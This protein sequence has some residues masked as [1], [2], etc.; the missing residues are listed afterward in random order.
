MGEEVGKVNEE[1]WVTLATN[2]TYAIGALV[3]AHSLK[4]VGTQRKL[5]ILVTKSLES[6]TMR[7]ALEETFDVVQDVEEMDSF[8]A[9]NLKLLQ[10]PELGIT[11]TKLHCWCLTQ[12]SKCVF[13]DADT[14]VMKF[15]DELFDRKE[16]SAAPD[17]GWP[18]CFNSGVFVF[19]PSVETFES[20][21]AFA[22]KEG[23]FDGGDQGLLNSY[24]DTW[25]T[26]DIETHLPFVYNMC[27]T[28]TYTYLPAYKKFGES[29]KIV[30]FI[31]MSK[32]WDAQRD[33]QSGRPISRAQD[34]HAG[35]HLEKW[36]SIYEA[37][38]K[39]ILQHDVSLIGSFSSQHP[40]LVH[41][42]NP[43]AISASQNARLV[44]PPKD[45][46]LSWEKGCPDYMGTASFDKILERIN[47]TLLEEEPESKK[48]EEPESK[49]E[50]E[51]REDES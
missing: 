30:H 11:F 35:D 39:P 10:R 20:L 40:S 21:V 2:E 22:Q 15:C 3:L 1:A 7:K 13:L 33:S 42:N 51:Q 50:E 4:K 9:V 28:A 34:S 5:A 12:F 6:K 17:A 16:L 27:A 49:K 32:P 46:R 19:K 18:D 44:C 29:V 47:T 25:A 14:F 23:S 48:E 37:H 24:F 26:Q 8:D 45:N 36:W 43:S 41:E 38:V 31:G